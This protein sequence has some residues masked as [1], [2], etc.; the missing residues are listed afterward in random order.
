MNRY[1]LDLLMPLRKKIDAIA[2]CNSQQAEFLCR[3]IPASCPLERDI[4]LGDRAIAHIP[5]L[6]KLNPF[7]EQLV[8]LRFRAQ[9]YLS[10]HTYK[11]Y[12]A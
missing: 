7:Y 4:K 11:N 10:E 2:I 6:C 8:R 5:S 9:C 1:R 3:F 12:L